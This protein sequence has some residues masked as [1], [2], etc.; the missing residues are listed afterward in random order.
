MTALIIPK[1]I[2]IARLEEY[3]DKIYQNEYSSIRIASTGMKYGGGLGMEAAVTQLIA[4]YARHHGHLTAYT[5][6]RD[7]YEE[8][9]FKNLLNNFY[10]MAYLALADKIL[11]NDGIKEY[12]KRKAF[13][14]SLESVEKLK[15]ADF[16]DAFKGRKVFFPCVKPSIS[17]GKIPPLYNGSNVISSA[18]F[19]WVISKSIS[20]LLRGAAH[21]INDEMI[22]KIAIATHQLFSNTDKHASYD[23]LGNS[24][25]KDARGVTINIQAYKLEQILEVCGN[26]KESLDYFESIMRNFPDEDHCSFIE[27]SVIDSGPGFAKRW[28]TDIH[29]KPIDEINP[30]QEIETVIKCFEKYNSSSQNQSSGS[31]LNSVL[32]SLIA[33]NGMF[34][35][36]TG[37]VVVEWFS[38]QK[39]EKLV[40]NNVKALN[41]DAAGSVF[42]F[43]IPVLRLAGKAN[44]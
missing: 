38:S 23:I 35:L 24:Y 6:V 17:G 39:S 10:G 19:E 21:R 27:V 28:L 13:E 31:G 15:T 20:K 36:R 4:T 25:L 29:Q 9:D 43:L 11:L 22:S 37:K 34:I 8:Q 33:L 32:L 3:Y 5:Y 2:S 14:N 26:N 18:A 40:K 16:V 44:V 7:G 12:S 1:D 30:S 42:T 41:H